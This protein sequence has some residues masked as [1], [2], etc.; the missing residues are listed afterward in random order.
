MN[1]SGHSKTVAQMCKS[2][3]LFFSEIVSPI[4][5]VSL[6]KVNTRPFI[7]LVASIQ[8]LQS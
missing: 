1:V 5:E 4:G 3:Y 2:S 6:K 8:L 7:H